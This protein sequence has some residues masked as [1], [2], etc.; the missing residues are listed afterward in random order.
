[1]QTLNIESQEKSINN[2]EHAPTRNQLK[3]IYK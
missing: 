2:L 1:M 3:K